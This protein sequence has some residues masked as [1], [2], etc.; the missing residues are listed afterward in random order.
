MRA[1]Q[2]QRLVVAELAPEC[3][4]RVFETKHPRCLEQCIRESAA[5]PGTSHSKSPRSAPRIPLL[6]CCLISFAIKFFTRS[7][8]EDAPCSV[9]ECRATSMC[10]S[11][12][13]ASKK[14]CQ[15]TCTHE[16][17]HWPKTS[18]PSTNDGLADAALE[19]L[20]GSLLLLL[21]SST[22]HAVCAYTYP[23]F[24]RDML[25]HFSAVPPRFGT[26]CRQMPES[27][28]EAG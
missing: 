7:R 14:K 21:P 8:C 20:Q 24:G 27:I 25:G 5:R 10:I 18:K 11:P 1:N 17:S 4:S 26:Y 12:G 22:R 19:F 16:S 13:M 3:C 6:G 9:M 2:G 23:D 28:N 15:E